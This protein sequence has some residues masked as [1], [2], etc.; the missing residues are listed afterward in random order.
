MT[1]FVAEN[2]L[3][4]ALVAATSD[5]SVRPNFYRCLLASNLYV[6]DTEPAEAVGRTTL[7]AGTT[8][9]IPT[10]EID[11]RP[12]TIA[13]SSLARL[14]QS[15]E[16]PVRF[17]EMRSTDF[18]HLTQGAH[19]VLN[20]GSVYGKQ[21]VPEEIRALLDGSIFAPPAARRITVKE[22]TQVLIGTPKDPHT[23][24]KEALSSVFEKRRDV[25]SAR[26][27][28]WFIPDSGVPAHAVVGLEVKGNWDEI[29]RAATAALSSVTSP[30]QIID[31]IDLDASSAADAIR[32]LDPFFRRRRLWP[33]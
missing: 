2:D 12:H 16:Q 33:F 18:F 30:D 3:E 24:L 27:A 28:W 19:V 5:A 26:L 22:A 11:G 20:P 8:V 10:V 31:F 23:G 14:Q 13:F 25:R 29:V 6:V 9:S 1:G 32:K 21:F 15:L 4:R 7:T 17:L